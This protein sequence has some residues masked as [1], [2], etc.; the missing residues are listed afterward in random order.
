[1]TLR[2]FFKS[3][4]K[5]HHNTEIKKKAFIIIVVSLFLALILE[6]GFFV[7]EPSA[8][9][10][11]KTLSLT[12]NK[13]IFI[14][15]PGYASDGERFFKQLNGAYFQFDNINT[16]FSK[17]I[18]EFGECFDRTINIHVDYYR[19]DG[20]MYFDGNWTDVRVSPFSKLAVFSVPEGEY[21]SLKLSIDGDFV[22]KSVAVSNSIV[23]MLPVTKDNLSLLRFLVLFIVSLASTALFVLWR[24]SKETPRKIRWAELCFILFC[25]VYYS[26]WAVIMPSGYGPDESMRHEVTQFI[27]ENGRLPIGEE[28]LNDL[29]GFSYAHLPTVLCNQL[30]AVFMKIASVFTERE[31]ILLIAARFVSVFS[32]T[33]SIYFLIKSSK[34]LFRSVSGLIMVVIVAFT[35]QFAFLASYANNDML[36][37]LGSTVIFYAWAL[38]INDKWNYKNALLLSIGMAVC[39]LSYYN[40]YAWIAM[41]VVIFFSTYLMEKPRNIKHLIKITGLIVGV[42]FLIAG[43]S[44]VRHLVLY[45]DLLGFTTSH[46]FGEL[47]A[48]AGMK[49]S[50]RLSLNER[51]VGIF[52]MLFDPLYSWFRTSFISFIGCFGYMELKLSDYTYS[53]FI[54]VFVIGILGFFIKTVVAFLDKGKRIKTKLIIFYAAVAMTAVITVFLSI[55]NSYNTDFQPQGRYCYPAFIA[56]AFFVAKGYEAIFKLIKRHNAETVGITVI[57]AAIIVVSI[58]AFNTVY[59]P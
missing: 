18:L 55:Y 9:C 50:E 1:M 41:S 12:E 28:L 21:D 4:I 24:S 16:T 2:E 14:N 54:L 43:Y 53:F 6:L 42:T 27:F 33:C 45:D 31:Y 37:F 38:A 15:H 48:P 29:W 7:F 25:F 35:P 26:V 49:P 44:F 10:M 32:A 36:A 8:K 59:L 30:G 5:I 52:T 58:T 46:H 34:L 22:L 57:C 3:I 23:L 39:A 56:L 11:G 19:T 40:S 47:Y 20:N 13:E 17:V 51:G